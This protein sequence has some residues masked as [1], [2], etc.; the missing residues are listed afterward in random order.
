MFAARS[1]VVGDLS[2]LSESARC[3]LVDHS[4]ASSELSLDSGDES[5]QR[6]C[7]DHITTPLIP[8][9]IDSVLAPT[10]SSLA[11]NDT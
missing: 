10:F 1:R 11:E 7:Q 2:Q 3:L 9:R 5:F 6:P 4:S 8:R